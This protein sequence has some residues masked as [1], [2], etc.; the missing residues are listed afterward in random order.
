MPPKRI[1]IVTLPL[2]LLWATCAL[3]SESTQGSDED[4][5]TKAAN[6]YCLNIADKAA[7]ARIAWQMKRLNELQAK[8]ETRISELEQ[9]QSE[10][11]SWIDRQQALLESAEKG[12]VEIYSTMDPD[13]AADQLAAL[14]IRIAASVLHQLKP[15]EA[16][17]IL[18]VMRTDR[19]AELVRMLASASA[20]P[21]AGSTQ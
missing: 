13:A 17:A 1:G 4:N 11:K 2:L 9:R 7:D 20:A 18:D 8:V 15:R 5:T 12:L 16:G 3:A 10:V 21:L 6:S 19:A 14:D